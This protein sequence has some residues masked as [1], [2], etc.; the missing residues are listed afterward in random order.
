MY[1]ESSARRDGC[2]DATKSKSYCLSF[3]RMRVKER[4]THGGGVGGDPWKGRRMTSLAY[5]YSYLYH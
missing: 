4:R 1:A 3:V 2:A 5:I